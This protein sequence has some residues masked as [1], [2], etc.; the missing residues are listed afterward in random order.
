[1]EDMGQLM[2]HDVC[3]CEER[4]P[5][6]ISSTEYKFDSLAR[7]PI[8]ACKLA[9][10]GELLERVEA[11]TIRSHDGLVHSRYLFQTPRS[12][13]CMGT[14]KRTHK[15]DVRIALRVALI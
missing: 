4:R 15:V 8:A 2:S 11:K 3:D 10:E 13:L 7:I 9:I 1:M 6:A 12:L 14:R 5:A